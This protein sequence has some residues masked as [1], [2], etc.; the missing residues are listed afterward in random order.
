MGLHW[1]V[2]SVKDFETLCWTVDERGDANM[3]IK[4]GD[5]V[6]HP[7]THALVM[8]SMGVG[9]GGITEKNWREWWARLS[10]LQ[11]MDGPYLHTGD[12][13]PWLIKP[14]DVHAH[15]GLTVNVSRESRAKWLRGRIGQSL[16]RR[17]F[18]AERWEEKREQGAA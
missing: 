6:L 7:M 11:S 12:G 14:S 16:D 10:L 3:G 15:I 2:R 17:A 4:P 13:E 8:M 18:Q 1:D 9:L 5:K